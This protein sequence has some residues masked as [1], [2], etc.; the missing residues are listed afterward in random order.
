MTKYLIGLVICMCI[1]ECNNED[2]TTKNIGGYS[3][4]AQE[5][6]DKYKEVKVVKTPPTPKVVEPV[7]PEPE[8][9]DVAPP[10]VV[11]Q[12]IKPKA[13]VAKAKPS[14]IRSLPPKPASHKGLSVLVKIN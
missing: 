13:P 11:K 1:Y 3:P 14:P 12:V 5:I 8:P 10:P 4:P 2:L 7:S 9:L 6:T